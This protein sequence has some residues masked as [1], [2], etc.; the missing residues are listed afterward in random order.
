MKLKSILLTAVALLATASLAP[1]QN[2]IW[3]YSSLGA[4]P[5]TDDKLFLYD[6]S[7]TAS[8]NITIANLFTS[9][10]LVT[11]TLGVASATTIN[12]LTITAPLS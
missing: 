12:K 2:N 10:T 3:G 8:K 4:A 11:P 6:T 7:A 9:P 5:A 1:V